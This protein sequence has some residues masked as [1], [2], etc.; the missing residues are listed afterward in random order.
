MTEVIHEGKK[1]EVKKGG[2][3]VVLKRVKNITDIKGLN[4]LAYLKRLDLSNNDITEI[5]GLEKL[6]NLEKLNLSDNKITEIKG[7]D[8]L[9]R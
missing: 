5:S 1:Y 3:R 8:T 6:T 7:L 4:K 2:L 9:N